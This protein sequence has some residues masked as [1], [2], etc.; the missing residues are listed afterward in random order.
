M[1][2]ACGASFQRGQILTGKESTELRAD[3]CLAHSSQVFSR[4]SVAE[5]ADCGLQ[6]LESFLQVGHPRLIILF[7]C[8]FDGI[9]ICLDL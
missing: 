7:P 5:V 4:V 8:F 6:L 2:S 9:E 3:P 1:L